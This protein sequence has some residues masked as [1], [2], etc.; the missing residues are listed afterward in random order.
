M[1]S[2]TVDSDNNP[3]LAFSLFSR[4]DEVAAVS[5][6]AAGEWSTPWILGTHAESDTTDEGVVLASGPNGEVWL[7]W[8]TKPI[9]SS[10]LFCGRIMMSHYEG[11]WGAPLVIAP[12]YQN[13]LPMIIMEGSQRIWMSWSRETTLGEPGEPRTT[14]YA[15]DQGERT[16]STLSSTRTGTSGTGDSHGIR[17]KL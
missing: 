2:L 17:M 5:R 9:L 1:R 8:I 15:Y 7:T 4:D 16:P 11:G 13:F 10:Y 12:D 3:W 14:W 6:Y